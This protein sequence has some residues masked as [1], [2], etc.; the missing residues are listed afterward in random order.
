MS[1]SLYNFSGTFNST[2]IINFIIL[3]YKQKSMSQVQV[4]I[5][6]IVSHQILCLLNS[7]F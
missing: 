2:V 5:I 3:F 4:V 7:F 6:I 1:S